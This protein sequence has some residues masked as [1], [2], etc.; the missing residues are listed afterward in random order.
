MKN[1]L[2]NTLQNPGIFLNYASN[3]TGCKILDISTN[4]IISKREAYL[5]ENIKIF[6]A[7]LKL[8]ELFY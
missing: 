2:E 4:S 8:S 1:K 7:L 6:L 5:M 3:F